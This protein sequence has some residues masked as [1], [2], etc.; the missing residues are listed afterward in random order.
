MDSM[1]LLQILEEDGMFGARRFG[2]R[3][4]VL[5][6]RDLL[7]SIVEIYS[8]SA[9]IPGGLMNA[10]ILDIGA[11]YGRLAHR[12]TNALTG[13]AHVYCADAIPLSTFLCEFYLK[14]RNV[15]RASAVPLPDL[16]STL[17]SSEISV[18]VNIHSFSEC[19]WSA[20]D[21]WISLL[22]KYRVRRLLIVPNPGDHGGTRLL[23]QES[24]G[25]NRE[26]TSLLAARSYRLVK[27]L[28][29]YGSNIIQHLGVTP[30]C[31]HY[32]ELSD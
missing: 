25:S 19:A 14:Y 8:L 20:I 22:H 3:D 24:D 23:T 15:E 13:V 2:F 4:S 26:Y 30:T 18:A 7:D 5:V 29:K 32:Y 11:G 31:H 28:P 27:V 6:S 10:S 9:Q 12:L 17:R 1:H 16:E 21:W